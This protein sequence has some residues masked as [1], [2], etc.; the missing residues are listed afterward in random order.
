MIRVINDNLNRWFM[1]PAQAGAETLVQAVRWCDPP[2]PLAVRIRENAII[3]AKIDKM[4]HQ[5]LPTWLNSL[6]ES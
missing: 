4:Q 2:K 6:N 3:Q 1:A 5:M